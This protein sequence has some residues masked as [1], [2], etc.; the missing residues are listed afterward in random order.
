[1]L[2]SLPGAID[3]ALDILYEPNAV[4]SQFLGSASMT[5][6]SLFLPSLPLLVLSFLAF[7][8]FS[9]LFFALDI[10]YESNAVFRQ[11]LGSASMTFFLFSFP[12]FLFSYCLFLLFLSFLFF[13]SLFRSFASL[14]FLSFPLSSSLFFVFLLS[15]RFASV[16]RMRSD[17]Y[18]V[19]YIRGSFSWV[20]SGIVGFSRRE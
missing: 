10:L 17:R 8:V 16:V 2:R 5:F 7:L 1:M 9:F 15:N 13:P 4:L 19:Q 12:R 20:A 11:F 6:F 14:S 18:C 3:D